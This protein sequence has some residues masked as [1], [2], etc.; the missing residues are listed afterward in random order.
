MT[1]AMR[2]LPHEYRGQRTLAAIGR[3]T[4]THLFFLLQL[5]ALSVGVVSDAMRPSMWRR[6]VRTEFWR[7]L[8][9][10]AGGGLAT[11]IFTGALVGLIL[12]SEALFWLG[13]AGESRLVGPIIVTVL[14]RQITPLLIGLILVGRAGVVTV[15]EMSTIGAAEQQRALL[16]QGLDPFTLF[17]LPRGIA[18][19]LASFTLGVIFVLVALIVGFVVSNVLGAIQASIWLFFDGVVAAMEGYDFALFPAV[20]LIIGLLIAAISCLT[21]ISGEGSDQPATVLPRSFVRSVVAIL[22][23]NVI[24]NLAA[25]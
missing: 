25:P 12:V 10:A 7:T 19:A 20:L 11:T 24:A 5:A 8:R 15:A 17:V 2:R 9:H 16:G 13:R 23:I 22:I 3:A 1:V 4:R 21:G 14:V 6:S 18:L